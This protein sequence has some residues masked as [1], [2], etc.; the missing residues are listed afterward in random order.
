MEPVAAVVID[1][2]LLVLLPFVHRLGAEKSCF[3]AWPY[4]QVLPLLLLGRRGVSVLLVVA[5]LPRLMATAAVAAAPAPGS[6]VRL[7]LLPGPWVQL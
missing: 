6:T 1:G 3:R 2:S 5:L 7:L 4:F